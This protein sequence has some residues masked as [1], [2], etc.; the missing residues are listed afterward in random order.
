ML[1]R[2]NVLTLVH[3]LTCHYYGR[4]ASKDDHLCATSQLHNLR[5]HNST[6]ENIESFHLLVARVDLNESE[7]TNGGKVIDAKI[8]SNSFV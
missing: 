1:S 2:I 5:Q 7:K 8:I 6:N 4:F 3:T